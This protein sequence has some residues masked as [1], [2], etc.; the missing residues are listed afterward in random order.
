VEDTLLEKMTKG[1]PARPGVY[2]MKDKDNAVIYVGKARNLRARVRSYI[3]AKDSRPMIPFLVSR[4]N[5]IEFVVT[6]TEKEALILENTLIKKNR[7]R[8][9]V[10]LR[11]D[12]NYFSIRVD[13]GEEY[14]RLELVRHMKNDGAR[15][16]GPYSS[17]QAVKE[18]LRS[19][20]KVFP[21]RTCRERAFRKRTRPCIEYEIK[22][23]SAP[24]CDYI[25]SSDYKKILS[26]AML[27]LEGREKKLISNLRLRMKEASKALKFEDA[28]ALRDSINAIEK[29]LERQRVVSTSFKD[30]DVYGLFRAGNSTQIYALY[31]RKGKIIGQRKVPLFKTRAGSPEIL[32]SFLK[33]YYDGDVAIPEEVIIP[34]EIEDRD[35]VTE[36]MRDKR[37]RKVS[38]LVPKRG[39]KADLLKIAVKNAENV[40]AAQKDSKAEREKT[41]HLLAGKLYLKKLPRRIE[42]FDISN[43]Q[44]KYAVGSMVSFRDGEPDRAGY[45]RFRIRT[46]EGADDYGM[47]REVLERRYRKGENLPDLVVVDGGKGQ[48]GVAISVAC[49]LGIENVDIIGLAKESRI[50]PGEGLKIVRKDVDRI[51]V[52]KRKN[53]VYLTKHPPAL[54]LLQRVRD[55]AHRFA[56]TYHRKLKEKG[57]FHSILDDIPGIGKK[58]KEALLAHFHDVEKIRTASKEELHNVPGIGK[59]AASGIFEHFSKASFP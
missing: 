56:V 29:T 13:P 10:T 43:L 59:E 1:A 50:M 23:C 7:P 5:D 27:F 49:E 40:F 55:E 26:D 28:A 2:L 33:Q 25:S 11:D 34:E 51:Y 39:G 44:G 19:I 46:K 16:F 15:Y 20:Q 17:S 3:G 4:I 37:R 48:L 38:L 12:K 8:Y 45:R 24:C 42:C 54:F 52:P 41:L 47:M 58:R 21:L 36:W 6:G 18:T 35:V 9:N 57:D 31:V 22:R 32:S 53:P 14:P 30:Q